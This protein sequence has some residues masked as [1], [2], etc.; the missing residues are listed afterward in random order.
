M[1]IDP[2][3]DIHCRSGACSLVYGGHQESNYIE[4]KFVRVSSNK[5]PVVVVDKGARCPTEDAV[6]A[7]DCMGAVNPG[8]QISPP[9]Y[10]AWLQKG[11]VSMTRTRL[12]QCCLTTVLF[13]AVV[14]LLLHIA[15]SVL[16]CQV[17]LQSDFKRLAAIDVFQ[18]PSTLVD[19]NCSDY[20]DVSLRTLCQIQVSTMFYSPHTVP[21]VIAKDISLMRYYAQRDLQGWTL[22]Y[23]N[24][25]FEVVEQPY[26]TSVRLAD[27][28]VFLCLGIQGQDKHCLRPNSY[29]SL[30]QGQRINQIHG[31]RDIL[32]RKDALCS[33]IG[34]ALVSYKG[35]RTFTFPCWVL[36]RD[37]VALREEMNHSK[38]DWIVKPSAKGEGHGIFV[39]QS[40][41]ELDN[42][43]TDGFVVQPLLGDPYLIHGKKF[44][45]R[46]YVLITS[47]HPLRA[48]IYREGL[49]RFASTKYDRNATRGG[50][51]Q[52]FLTN[53]SVGKK[54]AHISN[55]T[56]T[57]KELRNYFIQNSVDASK[58][59]EDINDAIVRTLLVS[60]YRFL[61]D[62][63]L[64]M[65]GYDCQHCFQLLGV[66]VILTSH[67]KPIVIE[68]R[69]EI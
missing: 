2:Y 17:V 52:Q 4:R 23:K 67:L 63:Y 64:A 28:S 26:H 49:V 25:S 14:L 27:L 39:V 55:L 30:Y 43:H 9:Q 56:W 21:L 66:D 47:M 22:A 18:H 34:E 35:E 7:V 61:R 15:S 60:E 37:R 51:E 59:F 46:T 33:T 12:L 38:G 10:E 31:L 3:G 58:V 53:T 57:F 29:Q 69:R 36:P 44:D 40:F 65:G 16:T 54:Y 32:W 19:L 8:S 62:F 20:S 45:F 48:Y 6:T 41:S 68:V 5:V 13:V 11:R 24:F 50:G 1:W 42:V